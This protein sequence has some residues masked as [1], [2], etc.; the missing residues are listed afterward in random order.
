MCVPPNTYTH[1]LPVI[2]M[3]SGLSPLNNLIPPARCTTTTSSSSIG[4]L[5]F[6]AAGVLRL[7]AVIHVH[8]HDYSCKRD[9]QERVVA[10]VECVRGEEVKVYVFSSCWEWITFFMLS[11]TLSLS[12]VGSPEG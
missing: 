4:R 3:T 9:M 11:L 8:P 6:S 10:M 7:V 5:L 1:P 12:F 2:M